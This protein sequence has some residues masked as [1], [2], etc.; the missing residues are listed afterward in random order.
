M[1]F[2]VLFTVVLIYKG[3]FPQ[4]THSIF[5][6]FCCPRF[7]AR[8]VKLCATLNYYLVACVRNETADYKS[9]EV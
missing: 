9:R 4:S 5:F 2:S 8:I 3:F 6:F 1:S 7:S